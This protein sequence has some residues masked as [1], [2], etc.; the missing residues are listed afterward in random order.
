MSYTPH[1]WQNNEFITAEKL[2]HIEEGI[3]EGGG[4]GGWDA[5]IRLTHAN[6]SNGDNPTDLTPSIVSGSFADL[7]A[8]RNNGKY[9]CILVEYYHPWG[10]RYSAPMGYIV[11]F[12]D[13][14]LIMIAGFSAI[15][16]GFITF[17]EL[18]WN[19][20]DLIGWY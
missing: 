9:P 1:E 15:S 20:E 6:N 16:N 4:G 11:Y 14:I 7:Y 13:A 5:V 18:S 17:G 12:G 8:K 2:N 3:A 19:N 10:M